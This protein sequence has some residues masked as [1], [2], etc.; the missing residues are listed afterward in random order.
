MNEKGSKSGFISYIIVSALFFTIGF[1]CANTIVA[2][3]I[4]YQ[5]G[6][7]ADVNRAITVE[8]QR[9]LER[10][11]QA[12]A[13]VESIRGIAEETDRALTEL[14]QLNRGSSDISKAI[15]E[16]IVILENNHRSVSGI[17]S[18]YDNTTGNK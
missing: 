2:R 14:G 15:R 12:I 17:L 11:Q 18:V 13:A 16:Q 7:A 10:N 8:Q 4:G 9:E 1:I 3:R 5:S 6:T